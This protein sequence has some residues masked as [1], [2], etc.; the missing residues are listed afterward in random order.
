MPHEDYKVK[1][2]KRVGQVRSNLTESE[3]TLMLDRRYTDV[4]HLEVDLD[5]LMGEEVLVRNIEFPA[6]ETA[7]IGILETTSKWANITLQGVTGLGHRSDVSKLTLGRVGPTL[8]QTL[9][10]KLGRQKLKSDFIQVTGEHLW[11][12]G[13]NIALPYEESEGENLLVLRYDANTREW[14]EVKISFIDKMDKTVNFTSMTFGIFA[15]VE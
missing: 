2:E 1:V 4:W 3:D 14:E 7:S 13:V 12:T 8:A 11:I 10:S 5:E 9:A 6:R 15:V